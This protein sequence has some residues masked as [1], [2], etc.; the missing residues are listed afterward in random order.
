MKYRLGVVV[1]WLL[2]VA[3][4]TIVSASNNA[5]AL[6]AQPLLSALGATE[7]IH[8]VAGNNALMANALSPNGN[9][10]EAI[11]QLGGIARIVGIQDN[12]A[13]ILGAEKFTVLD[14]SDP[15]APTEVGFLR[16]IR[17]EVTNYNE[18]IVHGDL[19][20]I[21]GAAS[22]NT[23]Y[24]QIINVANPTAPLLGGFLTVDNSIT[25]VGV[26]GNYAFLIERGVGMHIVDI[27]NYSIPVQVA[28]H[29]DDRATSLAIVGNYAYVHHPNPIVYDSFLPGRWYIFDITDPTDPSYVRSI[30]V[31]SKS[32]K[33]TH[34]VVIG[35]YFYTQD[36]V[37]DISEPSF[38][39]RLDNI[40][41]GFETGVNSTIR[42]GNYLYATQYSIPWGLS[43]LSIIDV[44][45]PGSPIVLTNSIFA[46][47]AQGLSVAGNYAWISDETGKVRVIDVSDKT[48]PMDTGVA[49]DVLA[50]STDVAVADGYIYSIGGN[51][52]NIV[53]VSNPSA[54]WVI[55]TVGS[56]NG[57]QKVVVSGDYAYIAAAS[58]LH[59]INIADKAA[60][61]DTGGAVKCYGNFGNEVAC[62]GRDLAIRGQ[63]VYLVSR[64]GVRIID[65]S[66]K[67][68][69][70]FAGDLWSPAYYPSE[71]R[72]I[73]IIGDF[74]YI[75]DTGGPT[76]K[77]NIRSLVGGS[78][79]SVDVPGYYWATNG[80]T[81]AAGYAYI[82]HGD[83]SGLTIVDVTNPSEPRFVTT[84]VL[85]NG[86][87]SVEAVGTHL[88]VS[89]GYGGVQIFS[90]ADNPEAPVLIGQYDTDGYSSDVAVTGDAVYVADADSGLAILRFDNSGTGST[91]PDLTID[92]IE[93]IQVL[94]G[95]DLVKNKDTAV[96]VVVRK[97]GAATSAVNVKVK[98]DANGHSFDR[99]Y[100]YEPDNL[101]SRFSLKDDDLTFS[102]K[103][104]PA[105]ETKIIYFFSDQ[106]KPTGSS[107][108]ATATV[109]P[110]NQ[111]AESNETNNVRS[112]GSSRP[113][114]ET[115]WNRWR[116]IGSDSELRVHYF[117]V[118][119]TNF[120][121]YESFVE[122]SANL[123]RDV[124][125]VANDKFVKTWTKESRTTQINSEP[126]LQAWAM[127]TNISL[128]LA[129]PTADRFIGILPNGWFK[130]HVDKQHD[131]RQFSTTSLVL[132]ED[133]LYLLF[134][135]DDESVVAHE[136]GHSFGLYQYC[137]QYDENCDDEPDRVGLEA[138]PGLWV[139]EM[140]PMFP[141][142]SRKIFS[143]M[144]GL[145]NGK[146]YWALADD[147]QYLLNKH[148][149]ANTRLASN[150]ALSDGIIVAAGMI[151]KTG[152]IALDDWFALPNGDL[153][154]DII[155]GP[156]SFT[157]LDA[158]GGI[159]Y[160]Q[161]FAIQFSYQESELDSAP[162][163]LKLPYFANIASVQIGL[164]DQWLGEKTISPTAPNV[165][166]LAPTPGEVFSSRVTV[167]WSASDVDNNSMT[168][169]L[170][171]SAD[172]GLQWDTIEH[173]L[174]TTS[175]SWDISEVPPGSQYV[176]K[177][178]ATDGFNTGE[179]TTNGTITIER[180]NEPPNTPTFAEPSD[181]AIDV[182]L[183]QLLN[184]SATDPDNDPL[185]YEVRFGTTNPPPQVVAG[186]SATTYDPP[187]DL[188]YSTTYY[189][190]IVAS[191]G[192]GG[193]TPG[194]VWSFTTVDAPPPFPNTFYISPSNNKKIG[195]I[196]AASADILRYEKS[197]N[198]WT[199]IYDGS[200]RGTPKNISA[201]DV[202][203]D[204]SLLLVFSAN[205]SLAINGAKVTVTPYD[206]VKFTPFDPN[207]FPLGQGT[208]SW[209]FQGK[210]YGLTTS[211]E[212][213]DAIDNAGNR[214]LLSTTGTAQVNLPG[215]K[216]LK[217]TMEDVFAFNTTSNKWESTL[218]IDG[219]TIPELKGKNINSVWDDPVSD[220]YYV[221]IAGTFKLGK[222]KG[223]AKSIVKL[224]PNGSSFTPSFVDW[225]A[226]G[227][228]FPSNLDG[229]DI[230]P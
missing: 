218:V 94:E 29:P 88:F 95:Q 147:Y 65:V 139:S 125:P 90:I 113:V 162:F 225:L 114:F 142:S 26:S 56:I 47:P 51:E 43:I 171:A 129:N 160:E 62:D 124:F 31:G 179:S 195:G 5:N 145:L 106:L 64:G 17:R 217:P 138:S 136:I 127:K 107:F 166:L 96:K 213:I 227:P 178:I 18:A 221:T 170:L 158:D 97:T 159:I 1:F 66:D 98:I 8:Q 204:G 120:S 77:L 33:L 101:D 111:I 155:P 60:P 36:G 57:A 110:Q 32:G 82:S 105:D 148:T 230:G 176:L 118:D 157:Y 15:L 223:N 85:E 200:V 119:I 228:I 183:G 164:E 78:S 102:L 182:P 161:N 115:E 75:W 116:I 112:M 175:Y 140:V 193:E 215:G 27:G 177:V 146:E 141:S 211:A 128:I 132:A 168:Y 190:Q 154:D 131:G 117:P 194:P 81:V 201:F 121:T 84:M 80:I 222:V 205:Q 74:M 206:V 163:V 173:G 224:T 14:I 214:L 133:N 89:N 7:S 61:Y 209:F 20:L 143:F 108:M 12:Y 35:D 226:P 42:N 185:T 54:P 87:N 52:L 39:Q 76:S 16:G 44:S 9:S 149:S 199:M 188:A 109:D 150:N 19:V 122:R 165:Q 192:R 100:V 69:P 50:R 99:F 41:S 212:K 4:I 24:L 13:Y 23:G 156:Y 63:T 191:D 197:T 186:Q 34:S 30:S 11:S 38:P 207:V 174:H 28:F 229:L 37:Y 72:A 86:V 144:G 203:N 79:G 67:A 202:M 169:T 22:D 3:C 216:L 40:S 208:Y 130:N 210:P 53:D 167:S 46:Q 126:E 48:A 25:G 58:G 134:D 103:F 83:D 68:N 153:S 184:W 49:Y 219:S 189:W 187:G 123:L 198:T 181:D 59:I 180:P 135:N 21:A 10:I 2:F 172:N 71:T 70:Y 104:G 55:G 91:L 92:S 73:A 137:E 6:A 151:D 93:P 220:D 152:Q 196:T 45:N